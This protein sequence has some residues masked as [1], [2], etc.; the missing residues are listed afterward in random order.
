MKD[1]NNI[2]LKL[3]GRVGAIDTKKSSSEVKC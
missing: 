1:Y 3:V 2:S